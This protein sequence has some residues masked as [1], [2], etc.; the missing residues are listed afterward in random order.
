MLLKL[1][2]AAGAIMALFA[3]WLAIGGP[4]PAMSGDIQRL[5]RQQ[6]DTAIDLYRKN[7]RD[8][9][10]LR[11]VVKDDPTAQRIVEEDLNEARGNLERAQKRKIE[12]SK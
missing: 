6:V 5:D 4:I 9:L 10:L 1:G 8:G 2:S 7:V 11:G 3:L 12:L